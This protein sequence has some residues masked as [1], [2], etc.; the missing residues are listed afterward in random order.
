MAL[1][2]KSEILFYVMKT[3]KKGCV[4][5]KAVIDKD[6]N[7][8]MAK[9]QDKEGNKGC[10]TLSLAD[11]EAAIAAGKASKGTGW[12]EATAKKKKSKKD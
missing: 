5:H 9:G 1:S 8:V 2:K 6:G 3:K 10:A 11:A 12:D 4:M 7:R